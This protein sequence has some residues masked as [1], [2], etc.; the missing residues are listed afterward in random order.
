[1]L[2]LV[3]NANI[4]TMN[5]DQPK[6]TAAVVNGKYFAYVGDE[7]G[8]ELYL[9]NNFPGDYEEL[10][11]SGKLIIPGFNDSH[12]HYLHYVKTKM[13]VNLVGVS[14][15]SELIE[16]MRSGLKTYD[17]SSG[18]WHVGEGWNQDQ[19]QD[20]KRFP[21]K[22]DLDEI[23]SEYPIMIQRSCG[24]VGCL[25]SKALQLFNI[26]DSAPPEY[27]KYAERG[28]DGT[29]NGIIKENLFDYFKLKLPAPSYEKLA[30][31]M[32]EYQYDMFAAGITSVQSDEYNYTPEGTFFLLQDLLR[33]KAEENSFKLRLGSQ[34]LYFKPEQLQ[35]A[36]NKGYDHT[37][38]NDS[39]KITATKLL[40][41]GSLGARTAYMR[42]PYAD[43]PSTRGLATF[44][45]EEL[46]EMVMLSHQNNTP[47]IIHA[48]GDGA[49][50][51]CLD[52]IEKA[53][54]AMPYLKPRHG[55]V[56]C[57][58]TDKAMIKK[59]KELNV[60]AYIQP[61]FIDYDMHIIYER[62]GKELAETSYAWKEYKDLGIHHPFG[63]DC[64]VESY[65]PFFGIYC[66]VTR[67][68][69]K[70]GGPY[71]PDQAFSV[72][73]AVYAYTAEGAYASGD[74]K[75]KGK[76][77]EGMLADFTIL[78]RDIFC[79]PPEEILETKVIKTF[80]AGECVFEN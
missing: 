68:G 1:M 50:Q 74:E 43:D 40:A 80:V 28:S 64:P 60:I 57:Q 73:D 11:C 25:N 22:Y 47:A 36:F 67:R 23:S 33:K 77:Q 62:V 41:D 18:L 12:M 48:I 71:L 13:H 7:K 70:D 20:E 27:L 10:D 61:V 76:I 45:Q 15:L 30:D 38:G 37:F 63:T 29:F 49:I 42:N 55:I 35:S 69:I 59:F 75:I 54:K 39:V 44:T 4:A 32:A 56:H 52:A 17:Y 58:V 8:A 5:K 53:Q 79:I 72:E 6:A 16:R 31:M 9:R 46:D 26:T 51:M 24:H 2:Y 34:A 21:T 65:N 19:F 14:S 3:K 78:N 66:A